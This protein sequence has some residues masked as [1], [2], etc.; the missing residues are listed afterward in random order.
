MRFPDLLVATGKPPSP[1]QLPTGSLPAFM[2]GRAGRV[3]VCPPQRTAGLSS[4]CGV[5]TRKTTGR[6]YLTSLW[7]RP[8][9]LQRRVPT[10]RNLCVSS[11]GPLKN[12][13][14]SSNYPPCQLGRR[15]SP[16]PSAEPPDEGC[17]VLPGL[18]SEALL[19]HPGVPRHRPGVG[20]PLHAPAGRVLWPLTC[21]PPSPR[22]SP[23]SH[24]SLAD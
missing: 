4:C 21:A 7:C 1:R 6:R 20:L 16:S 24:Q 10:I 17:E 3:S 9:P 12:Y 19:P 15:A 23:S 5:W 22:R 13:P 2:P 8:I 18:S 11:K 14:R